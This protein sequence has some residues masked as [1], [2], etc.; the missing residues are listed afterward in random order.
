MYPSEMDLSESRFVGF[1]RRM[2]LNYFL[3]IPIIPMNRG[4]DKSISENR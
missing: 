1:M 2:R 4:S 3:I